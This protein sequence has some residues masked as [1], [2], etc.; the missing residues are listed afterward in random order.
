[1]TITRIIETTRKAWRPGME[2]QFIT[3]QDIARKLNLNP[4]HVRD[5]L[6]KRPGFP[7]AYTFGGARRWMEDDIDEW[8]EKQRKAKPAG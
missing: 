3:H 5:R 1:M 6:T 7:A 2:G 8:I 4:D